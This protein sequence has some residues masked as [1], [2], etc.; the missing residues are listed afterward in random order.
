MSQT[1]VRTL[2]IIGGKPVHTLPFGPTQIEAKT[3]VT[4]AVSPRWFP[5]CTARAVLNNLHRW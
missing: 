2:F 5:P 1:K 3:F 4:S